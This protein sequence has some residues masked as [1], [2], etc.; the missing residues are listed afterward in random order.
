MLGMLHVQHG[1]VRHEA[2]GRWEGRREGAGDT[3]QETGGSPGARALGMLRDRGAR[4]G[5]GAQQRCGGRRSEAGVLG[6]GGNR[7]VGVVMAVAALEVRERA[8]HVWESAK[9]ARDWC[10]PALT[11]EEAWSEGIGLRD[12]EGCTRACIVTGASGEVSRNASRGLR[13]RRHPDMRC[14]GG[15]CMT[16]IVLPWMLLLACCC[17]A[18]GKRRRRRR[19]RRSGN[20]SVRLRQPPRRSS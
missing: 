1:K 8:L 17:R 16:R 4:A 11:P 19:A 2:T 9:P 13:V 18:L 15:H 7:G 3:G 10:G 20:G 5:E 12:G 14:P 6:A